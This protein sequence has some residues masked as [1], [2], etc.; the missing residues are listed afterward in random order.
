MK[1]ILL[2]AVMAL[3]SLPASAT[4]L[5][6]GADLSYA[7]QMQDCKA[8]YRDNGTPADIFTVFKNHGANL[9]R[10]RIWT[11]GQAV[12]AMTD[13]EDQAVLDTLTLFAKD[14]RV[15]ARRVLVLRTASNYSRPGA[16]QPLPVA[17]AKGGS[18]AGFEAAYRVGAPVVK[19]LVAGWDH[20][21]D[22]IPQDT[23]PGRAP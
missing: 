17:F 2:A 4:E 11:D 22:T 23:A 12:L 3:C 10:V 21:A 9:I 6:F 19:A 14:G 16:G 13:G 5:Y 15:D 18:E 1:N 8:V 20:Y 7:G